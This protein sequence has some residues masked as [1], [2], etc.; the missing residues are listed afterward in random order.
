MMSN[1][2]LTLN[3]VVFVLQ[4]LCFFDDPFSLYPILFF[5][6]LIVQSILLHRDKLN[7]TSDLQ[8]LFFFFL[9]FLSKLNLVSEHLFI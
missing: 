7:M 9:E 4:D 3:M 8:G 5:V 2:K 1:F 6:D